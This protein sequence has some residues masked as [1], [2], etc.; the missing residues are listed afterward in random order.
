MCKVIPMHKFYRCQHLDYIVVASEWHQNSVILIPTVSPL[1][2]I[3]IEIPASGSFFCLQ[4]SQWQKQN[5]SPLFK[6]PLK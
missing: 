2:L 6:L 1:L 3:K 4:V 5:V